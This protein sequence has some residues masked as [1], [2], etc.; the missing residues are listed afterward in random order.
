MFLP[1]LHVVLLNFNKNIDLNYMESAMNIK[2]FGD[3][4]ILFFF[5]S[6]C[7][8]YVNCI[9]RTQILPEAVFGKRIHHC[10][11]T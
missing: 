5:H 2:V 8:D 9:W 3:Y 4:L 11:R 10:L 6:K 7:Y 1:L